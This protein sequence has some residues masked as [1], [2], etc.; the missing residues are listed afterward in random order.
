MYQKLLTFVLTQPVIELKVEMDSM[1]GNKR[2]NDKAEY[3]FQIIGIVRGPLAQRMIMTLGGA[4]DD[5]Q[6]SYITSKDGI[7]AITISRTVKAI[8]AS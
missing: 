4:E 2:R 7:P 1:E 8:S 6:A 3:V 5:L